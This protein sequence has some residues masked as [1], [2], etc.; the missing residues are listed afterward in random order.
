MTVAGIIPVTAVAP[1]E[2]VKLLLQTQG[3][4]LKQGTITRPYNG[5][6]GCIM[7]TFRNEG[8]LSFWRGNL[9]NCFRSVCHQPLNFVF[10]DKVKCMFKQNRN[11][12]YIVNFGKNIASGSLAGALSLCFVYSLDYTR[13]R[14]TTDVK[15]TKKGGGERKHAMVTYN[16][17]VDVYEKTLAIDG[18]VGLYRGFVI[19]CVEII[20]YRGCYFGLY[21]TLK[22]ILIGPDSGISSSFLLGYCIPITSGFISYPFDT[23]VRRMMITSGQPVKY[24]GSMDCMCQILR[25]EGVMAF[26]KGVGV[27]LLRGIAGAGLLSSSD[28]LVTLYI[29]V[30]RFLSSRDIPISSPR[31]CEDDIGT[32]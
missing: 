7:Q 20:I 18:I 6:I 31:G 3:E 24:K 1:I 5:T 14:L 8:L 17:L 13:T 2:C 9:T 25:T 10:K 21:D 19:S 22:P 28:K 27:T 32:I 16:G 23:I 12:P 15:S 29:S 26:Y 4:M 30:K 11:Y